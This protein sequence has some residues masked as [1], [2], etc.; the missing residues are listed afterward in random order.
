MVG[1]LISAL[2]TRVSVS[3]ICDLYLAV[4]TTVSAALA[5]SYDT[6]PV[7]VCPANC[8]DLTINLEHHPNCVY[9]HR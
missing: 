8:G 5:L 9:S 2:P 4:I 6:D 3:R 7:S 1:R